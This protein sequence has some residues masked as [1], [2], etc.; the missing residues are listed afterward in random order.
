MNSLNDD[1]TDI[2]LE[3][4]EFES[5]LILPALNKTFDVGNTYNYEPDAFVKNVN[6]RYNP[7]S[8]T[9]LGKVYQESRSKKRER[10]QPGLIQSEEYIK[11]DTT[12]QA[13]GGLYGSL[14]IEDV[15]I[16]NDEKKSD[17]RKKIGPVD[18]ETEKVSERN[19]IY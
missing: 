11:W 8:K 17:T 14:R 15:E 10:R 13:P 6:L 19:F 3:P 1:L 12:G 4:T 2:K 9:I 5:R 18:K 16:K 7:W